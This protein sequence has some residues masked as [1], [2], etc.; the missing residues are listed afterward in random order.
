[1]D[2][3]CARI[4]S[5]GSVGWYLTDHLGSI[6]A[7]MNNS[8]AV[9]DHVTYD[10]WGN[11]TDSNPSAGDRY[12]FTGQEYDSVTG[13]YYDRAR[14]YDAAIGRFTSQ[15][16]MGFAAGDAN[17]YRYVGNASTDATDPSGLVTDVEVR[18]VPNGYTL[19]ALSLDISTLGSE[20]LCSGPLALLGPGAGMPGT[21]YKLIAAMAARLLAYFFPAAAGVSGQPCFAALAGIYIAEKLRITKIV[22]HGHFNVKYEQRELVPENSMTPGSG[23]FKP[24]VGYNWDKFHP[25]NSSPQQVDLVLGQVTRGDPG[26][27]ATDTIDMQN[28]FFAPLAKDIVMNLQEP[29]LAAEIT[30][31]FQTTLPLLGNALLVKWVNGQ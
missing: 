22:V 15:D 30:K 5:D 26:I 31:A 10:P 11:P 8:G 21:A 16:P 24:T 19:T 18:I 2:A 12:K 17:L 23:W 20:P 29:W 28:L 4:G 6:G 9:I 13:Q 27:L 14:M 3:V 7:I 25:G 1:V